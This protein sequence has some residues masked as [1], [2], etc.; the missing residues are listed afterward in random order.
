[1]D[2]QGST[3]AYDRHGTDLSYRALRFARNDQTALPGFD[4]DHY[5]YFSGAN[6]RDIVGLLEE[7]AAVR[8]STIMLLN[9]LPDEALLRSGIINGNLYLL[10]HWYIILRDM[11][12][13]ISIS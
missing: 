10:A 5:V 13:I 12:C 1:M 3:H 9:G 6:D 2:H 8:H 7:F 11:N 4:D